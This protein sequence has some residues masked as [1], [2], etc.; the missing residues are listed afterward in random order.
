MTHSRRSN[1]LLAIATLAGLV[2]IAF[3]AVR[4]LWQWAVHGGRGRTIR[5]AAL[6]PVAYLVAGHAAYNWV[7]YRDEAWIVLQRRAGESAKPLVE[8]VAR[9]TNP[10]DLLSS[11]HDAT[12]YLYTG[13][14]GVPTSTFLARQRVTPFTPEDHVTWIR[15]MI[16][17]FEPRYFISGFTAHVVAADTLAARTP[18]LLRR[19]GWIPN[20]AVYER[21]A[22]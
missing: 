14:R 13:R 1:F 7:Q 2:L 9:Y 17:T 15:R 4:P 18:P 6:V 11:E 20:H 12:V 22:P 16:E 21:I 5:L 10:E 19:L 8:W 3:V